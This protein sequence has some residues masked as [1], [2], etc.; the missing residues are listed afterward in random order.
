MR[1]FGSAPANDN[2]TGF[3]GH[4]EDD[5]SGLVYMQARY[6][7]PL[8]GRF[9]AT[10]PIGY[11]DQL[12]L[13][14]YVGNDPVNFVDLDGLRVFLATRQVSPGAIVFVAGIPVYIPPQYHMYL[15]TN[16]DYVSDPKATVYS[17]GPVPPKGGP[18]TSDNP[19][20]LGATDY[21]EDRKSW[22]DTKGSDR[23]R[24]AEIDADDPV[25]DAAASATIG[26]PDYDAVPGDG[27]N[28]NSAAY[29]AAVEADR[30]S[31]RNNP[32]ARTPKPGVGTPGWDEY[33]R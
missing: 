24:Y 17:W 19:K 18:A 3:T 11:Q 20:R 26:Y 15:V 23:S 16:A 1:I 7:D 9:L 27:A 33:R 6:Y 2:N 21:P 14:A 22:R 5:A 13:Y 32:N 31:G 30:A 12:N 10:D 8:V 4:L 25:A 28:S 29:R